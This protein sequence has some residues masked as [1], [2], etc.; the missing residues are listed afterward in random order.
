MN[1]QTLLFVAVMLF[2]AVSCSKQENIQPLDRNASTATH[3]DLRDELVDMTEEE[4]IFR[5]IFFLQGNIGE[6]VPY[7]SDVQAEM[8]KLFEL[9]PELKNQWNAL[10][11]DIMAVIKRDNP[12]FLREFTAALR[13]GDFERI[14]IAMN[15]ASVVLQK[16]QFGSETYRNMFLI[17]EHMV[18]NP[19][20]REQLMKLDLTTEEGRLEFE[21]IINSNPEISNALIPCTPGIAFCVAH[22][23]AAVSA[24]AL[25]AVNVA[26][27]ATVIA[28]TAMFLWDKVKFWSRVEGTSS[29]TVDELLVADLA[30]A[31]KP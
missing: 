24:T 26:A 3:A 15:E 5:E 9:N 19:E 11:D 13:S 8:S 6:R 16:A 27:Y 17:G 12:G 29:Y 25:A 18:Q 31:Y 10:T 7:L 20:L 28:K 14:K 30:R 23:V 21:K 22:T 4:R 1:K 2:T